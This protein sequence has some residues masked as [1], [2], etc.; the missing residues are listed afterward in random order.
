MPARGWLCSSQ[1]RTER[2]ASRQSNRA[3]NRRA[4]SSRKSADVPFGVGRGVV[5]LVVLCV[6]PCAVA[7]PRREQRAVPNSS[8]FPSLGAPRGTQSPV[9]ETERH[10]DWRDTRG[11]REGTRRRDI[12]RRG[13]LRES[14]RVAGTILEVSPNVPLNEL[15][16]NRPAF[17]LGTP[18]TAPAMRAIV[19]TDLAGSVEQTSRLG[20]D[21]RPERICAV[22]CV[23]RGGPRVVLARRSVL[24]LTS[25]IR[26]VWPAA[27]HGKRRSAAKWFG[28]Q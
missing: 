28:N 10:G 2:R 21:G 14:L 11:P 3:Q 26:Q 13:P 18:Y 15:L 6:V 20:D 27:E 24:G 7:A 9:P 22:M 19:F 8:V 5:S 12:R 4:V 16:G 25:A 17:P 1:S 23:L